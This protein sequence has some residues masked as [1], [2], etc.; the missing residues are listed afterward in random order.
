MKQNNIHIQ[1]CFLKIN[2][3]NDDNVNFIDIFNENFNDIDVFNETFN[4]KK[5]LKIQFSIACAQNKK[6][7]QILKNF[8]IEKRITKRFFLIECTITNNQ[9]QY[10]INRTI[11]DS[12]VDFI[13]YKLNNEKFLIFNN[14]ELRLKLI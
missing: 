6:Y 9:I 8:R 5:F 2:I 4:D 14:D 13:K 3:L 12:N 7:Q 1:I 10:R 11:I